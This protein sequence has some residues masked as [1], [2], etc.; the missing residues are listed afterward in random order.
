MA[1]GGGGIP[2]ISASARVFRS[3]FQGFLVYCY[4]TA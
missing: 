3:P 4:H 2:L 1:A